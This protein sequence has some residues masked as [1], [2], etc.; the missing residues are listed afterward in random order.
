MT[1]LAESASWVAGIYQL[2]TGDPVLA[3]PDGIDN[4]QAKQL[5]NRTSY[6]KS[7]LEAL[8]SGA[9]AAGKATKL[10]LARTINGVP[11][12]G[13]ADIT[14]TDASKEP[15][16]EAGTAAQYWKGTKDWADLA[17]DIRAAVLTGLST[18]TSTAVAASDSILVALGKLQAQVNA[19]LTQATEAVSGIAKV[20]TQTLVD[21]GTDDA[22]IV[23]PKKLRL[24]FLSSLTQNGYIVFPTWLGGLVIQWG[25]A[26]VVDKTALSFNLAFPSAC[27]VVLVTDGTLMTAAYTDV[28]AYGVAPDNLTKT[29]ATIRSSIGTATGNSFWLAFGK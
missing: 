14:I 29:S 28:V 16:I 9:T 8:V 17:T 20:A 13:T 12:D 1:T 27:F 5:A 19:A 25:Q 24:G 26:A 3:G 11:F 22:T 18:A 7:V 4:L 23:T 15:V 2:E 10:A 6:L 21:A